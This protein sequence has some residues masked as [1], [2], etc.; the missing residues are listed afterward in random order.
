MGAA[1]ASL[2]ETAAAAAATARPLPIPVVKADR[3]E[4]VFVRGGK[5][6][7]AIGDVSFTIAKGEFVSLLGPSGCGK[8]SFLNLIAGLDFPTSG[9]ISFMGKRVASINQDVGYVTQ[10]DTLLPWRS[11]RDNIALPLE[12]RGVSKADALRRTD[13]YIRLVN[14]TG[15]E[16]HFSARLRGGMRPRV[17]IAR[18]LVYQP[19]T[20]LFDEPFAAL[21][22]QLRLILQEELLNIWERTRLTVL[23]VTHDIAE[24]ISLSDRVILLSASPA[25]VQL[26]EKIDIPRPR[27]LVETHGTPEFARYYKKIWDLLRAGFR[28]GVDA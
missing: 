8:S 17:A 2:T 28:R 21:D 15:F 9:E 25:E 7:K 19:G 11:V 22:A 13:E 4:K 20:I 16:D 14:L 18:T 1:M 3:I 10:E 24:A 23:F 5:H 26:D 6:T 12:L 27:H